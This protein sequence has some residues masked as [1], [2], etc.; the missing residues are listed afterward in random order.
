MKLTKSFEKV[1]KRLE[2]WHILL[3]IKGKSW[4]ILTKDA[5]FHVHL[6]DSKIDLDFNFE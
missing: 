6:K 5:K 1:D 3:K 2:N 4:N